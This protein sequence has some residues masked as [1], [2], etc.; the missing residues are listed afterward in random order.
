MNGLFG[1]NLSDVIR[2]HPKIE[3]FTRWL[4]KLT[5]TYDLNAEDLD[6]FDDYLRLKAKININPN[7]PVD[8]VS[9]EVIYRLVRDFLRDLE[10]PFIKWTTTF[11]TGRESNEYQVC[12]DLEFSRKRMHQSYQMLKELI[13]FAHRTGN[14]SEEMAELISHSPQF[15]INE[16]DIS[17]LIQNKETIFSEP[18]D[19][20]VGNSRCRPK[21]AR[22]KEQL[23][24]K[25][26]T[27]IKSA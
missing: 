16:R 6:R 22:R 8:G 18:M 17:F 5:K 13:K 24:H 10:F 26:A 19:D 9:E 25:T 2:S 20:D 7:E 14:N 23:E 3:F 1:H 15:I 4:N 12:A 21:N 11:T 27:E